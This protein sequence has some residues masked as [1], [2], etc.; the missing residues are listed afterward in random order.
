MLDHSSSSLA[1][2]G[3]F[4]SFKDY[5]AENDSYDPTELMS[6][7]CGEASIFF[8]S[9]PLTKRLYLEAKYRYMYAEA[10]TRVRDE[11]Q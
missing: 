3:G 4:I 6:K 10:M 8:Y 7:Y 9:L 11:S 1:E 2:L 5:V